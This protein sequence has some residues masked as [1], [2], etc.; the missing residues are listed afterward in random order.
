MLVPSHNLFSIHAANSTSAEPRKSLQKCGWH[1]LEV[2]GERTQI[3][4]GLS[5]TRSKT[6]SFDVV[7]GEKLVALFDF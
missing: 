6:S 7:T 1:C 3:Y 2:Y 4:I 5:E